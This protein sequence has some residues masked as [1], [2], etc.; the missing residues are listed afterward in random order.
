M[1]YRENK[2]EEVRPGS[3]F[4]NFTPSTDSQSQVQELLQGLAQQV[5]EAKDTI[6]TQTQPFGDACLIFLHG[7]PGRGKTHLVEALVNEIKAAAPKV[8]ARMVLSRGR[9]YFDFQVNDN[10]YGDAPIVI[11]DDMFHDKQSVKDLHPATELTAFMKFITD[12][13]N[14][15]RLVIVTSN[16]GLVKGGILDRIKEE[17]K[18]GRTVSRAAEV[19]SGA[20]E[21]EL[22]GPD[23]RE[24]LAEQR[25]GKGLVLK[26]LN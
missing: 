10:P 7:K 14:H 23:Y 15:K 6:A 11:I 18:V 19:M 13:Y 20:G 2:I 26:I 25:R 4:E 3:T 8:F 9:L 24:E 21:F 12:L 22:L 16:F 5:I 17:D 1:S